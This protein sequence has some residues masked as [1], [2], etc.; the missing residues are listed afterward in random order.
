ML[1]S[2]NVYLMGVSSLAI[3]LIRALRLLMFH[4]SISTCRM[5]SLIVR[6]SPGGMK[7]SLKRS[8]ATDAQS[9]TDRCEMYSTRA[10]LLSGETCVSFPEPYLPVWCKCCCQNESRQSFILSSKRHNSSLD[11]IF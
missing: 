5:L 9:P 10:M 11:L 4:T 2:L 7:S 6:E 3:A 1:V 8:S